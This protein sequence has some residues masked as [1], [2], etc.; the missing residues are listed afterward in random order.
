MVR[1]VPGQISRT[2]A[3]PGQGE[4]GE[5]VMSYIIGQFWP[6]SIGACSLAC[7]ACH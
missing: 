7:V 1:V 5:H 2:L 6:W 3:A 4:G